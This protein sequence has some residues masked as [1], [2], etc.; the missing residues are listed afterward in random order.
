MIQ[1]YKKNERKIRSSIF[2]SMPTK[3]E[4]LDSMAQYKQ[5]LTIFPH[6]KVFY[7]DLLSRRINYKLI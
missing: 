4:W 7:F 6:L 1:L 2:S 3:K 5:T